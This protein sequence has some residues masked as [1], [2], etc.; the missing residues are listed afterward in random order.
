MWIPYDLVGSLKPETSADS[1]ERSK[2][3]RSVR[4]VLVGF[5][6]R[7]PVTQVW[8]I[9]I[10][11]D[12]VNRALTAAVDGQRAEIA[13][14]G[15]E[16]GKL[17]EVIY[18][19]NAADPF[20]ALDACRSD[21]DERLARWTLEL[22][23][24]MA[25][26]GWRLADPANGARWRCTPFRPSALDLDLE[27]MEFAPDDLKPLARLYQRTRNAS[28]PAWR[29]LNAYAILKRWRAGDA[30]FRRACE[31]PIPM[32]TFEM[33]AHSG[34]L[35][36]ALEFKDR[37]L[38]VLVDELRNWRDAAL[39]D[40]EAPGEGADLERAGAN[41]RFARMAGLADLAA[42]ETLML[43]IARRRAD[44]APAAAAQIVMQV[45]G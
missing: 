25:V 15:G 22:G 44:A 12:S 5:F 13:F 26:A 17:N 8:D 19:T 27:A 33:L 14:Y 11:T 45:E 37:P 3:D 35:A 24:G 1:V 41:S 42:R 38:S 21:L 23:R 6:L 32:V 31:P 28:D 36:C 9:D 34:A 29:L 20:N 16:S 18:R 2:A 40:L 30:P 7:N 4:S 43:E 10:R 39:D